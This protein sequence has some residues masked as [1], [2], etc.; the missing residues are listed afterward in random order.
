MFSWD[1]WVFSPTITNTWSSAGTLSAPRLTPGASRP[2]LQPMPMSRAV[3]GETCAPFLCDFRWPPQAT[4]TGAISHG[5]PIGCFQVSSKA[6]ISWRPAG[7]GS[8]SAAARFRSPG[9]GCCSSDWSATSWRM[10]STICR[11]AGRSRLPCHSEAR[12]LRSPTGSLSLPLRR[13]EPRWGR[14]RGP[15]IAAS[16]CVSLGRAIRR[17]W[18]VPASRRRYGPLQWLRP[19]R[20]TQHV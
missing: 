16:S 14:R 7:P 17:R 20:N 4:A 15:P 5:T 18:R 2:S 12:Q 19:G 11:A 10:R 3:H 1:S 9:T 6:V 13:A 8:C